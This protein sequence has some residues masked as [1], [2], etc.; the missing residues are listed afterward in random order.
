[1]VHRRIVLPS[2]VTPGYPRSALTRGLVGAR[3]PWHTS[4][5]GGSDG[6][7]GLPAHARAR[8]PTTRPPGRRSERRVTRA[9]GHH[10]PVLLELL[11]R[12]VRVDT[13]SHPATAQLEALWSRCRPS[14]P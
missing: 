14:H 10:V 4:N 5:L 3:C 6:G 1:M 13:G 8:V 2:L 7:Q 12:R 9:S 11:G